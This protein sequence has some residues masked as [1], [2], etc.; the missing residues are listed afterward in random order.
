MISER[1]ISDLI[2]I[3]TGGG[4][5]KQSMS[6]TD[7]ITEVAAPCRADSELRLATNEIFETM[8][9]RCGACLF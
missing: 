1:V 2:S 3:K 6:V 5:G 7:E 9:A 4:C 8:Q